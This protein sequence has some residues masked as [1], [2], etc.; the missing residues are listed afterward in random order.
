MKILAL[1][2]Q[3]RRTIRTGFEKFLPHLL[4][5]YTV[6][7]A[8]TAETGIP[9]AGK[10]IFI[11]LLIGIEGLLLLW[12]EKRSIRDIATIV[13]VGF[14]IWKT[15]AMKM[16]DTSMMLYPQPEQVFAVYYT[17]WRKILS[18]IGSSMY[19]LGS[20]FTL[21]VGLGIMLGIITGIVCRMREALLPIAKVIAP[22]PPIIYTPYAVAVLPSFEIASVFVIFSSIFWPVYIQMILSVSG[23]DRKLLDSARALNLKPLTLL[24][25]VLFP[26]CLPRI[27]KTL[28][29]SIA[30][31]FMVLTAAEMIGATSGLGYFV[32]YYADFADYTRVIA[33]ILLIGVVVS[34]LNIAITWLERSLIRWQ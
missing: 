3:E 9:E 5:L 16:A 18:G 21:A 6:V 14:I 32:R 28:P 19:L 10:I 29:I 4:I 34:I 2:G 1:K 30:N 31:A 20:G 22:I 27:M 26:Y 33:G 23:I 24:R 17:D 13:A 7:L 8:G 15:A 12:G 11:A 25:R